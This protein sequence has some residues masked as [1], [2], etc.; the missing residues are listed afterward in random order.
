MPT[1][2]LKAATQIAIGVETTP[3]TDVARTR[4]LIT[5]NASFRI[6]EEQDTFEDHHHGVLARTALAPVPTGHRTELELTMDLDFEQI[7]LPLLA[8]VKGDVT[9]TQPGTGEAELWTFPPSNTAVVAPKT[10]SLEFVEANFASTP[11]VLGKEALYGF[12]TGFEI[13]G[14]TDGLPQLLVSMVARKAA[15][16]TKTS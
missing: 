10:Y 16:T 6:V 15:S 4:R 5:R 3:G 11:D 8:G 1:T 12:C 14:G 13:R 9:T 2:A 7:L